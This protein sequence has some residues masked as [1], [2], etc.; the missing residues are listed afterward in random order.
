MRIAVFSSLFLMLACDSVGTSTAQVEFENRPDAAEVRGETTGVAVFR[1]SM[2]WETFWSENHENVHQRRPVPPI[3]SVDFG[4]RMLVAIFWGPTSG[5]RTNTTAVAAVGHVERSGDGLHVEV[6]PLPDFGYCRAMS[7]PVQVIE[8]PE[9]DGAVT[10]SGAGRFD[11]TVDA[12]R[13]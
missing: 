7:Y 5:C 1:S 6:G 9:S 4:H 13:R 11:H 3:P 2:E 12:R 10:V 8:V